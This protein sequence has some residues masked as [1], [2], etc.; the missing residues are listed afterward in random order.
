MNFCRHIVLLAKKSAAGQLWYS[1]SH[2]LNKELKDFQSVLERWP[3]LINKK[4]AAILAKS[5]VESGNSLTR[6]RRSMSVS[7]TSNIA[8]KYQES[9]LQLLR[10]ISPSQP[11]FD[12]IWRR[13]RKRRCSRGC[14]KTKHT[15]PGSTL[16]LPFSL[17]K[18]IFRQR[19]D[20]RS[21]KRRW[22]S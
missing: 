12:Q 7:K 22:E 21:R 8:T 3:C 9:R 17:H 16:R 5:Q 4:T 2:S 1:I 15:E 19:Q 10:S 14:S 18:G 20:G 13:E 11:E 6:I